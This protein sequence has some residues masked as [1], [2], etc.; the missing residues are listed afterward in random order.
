[1]CEMGWDIGGL[2]RVKCLSMCL[3]MGESGSVRLGFSAAFSGDVG[4]N[5]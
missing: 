5:G 1:M 2:D 4:A 3:I